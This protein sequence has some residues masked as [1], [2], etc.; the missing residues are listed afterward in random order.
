MVATS[1]TEVGYIAIVEAAQEGVWLKKF[2]S[3]LGVVP[4]A[5]DAMA[6]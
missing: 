5:L 2:T 1:T 4:S 6:I 3:E